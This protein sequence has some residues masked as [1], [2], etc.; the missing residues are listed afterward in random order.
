MT[1]VLVLGDARHRAAVA[2]HLEAAGFVTDDC[3]PALGDCVMYAKL[4]GARYDAFVFLGH[5]DPVTRGGLAAVAERAV[6]V[7]LLDA[8]ATRVDARLLGYLFRLPRALGF[9]DERERSRLL[10]WIPQASAVPAEVLG[11]ELADVDAFARLVA[12]TRHGRW[13]WADLVERA[14]AESGAQ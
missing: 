3:D 12:N 11:S 8:N 2:V 7:P 10:E 9:R 13:A 4:E 5:D 6:L 14:V 1:R